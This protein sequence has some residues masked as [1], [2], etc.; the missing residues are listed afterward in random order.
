MIK[1]VDVNARIIKETKFETRISNELGLLCNDESSYHRLC[2]Q[3]FGEIF[4]FS[5]QFLFPHIFRRATKTLS[6]L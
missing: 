6:K 2:K 5:S 1:S 3:I 4:E